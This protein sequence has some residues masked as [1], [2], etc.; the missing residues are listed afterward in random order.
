MGDNKYGYVLIV[1]ILYK[2]LHWDVIF[3]LLSY[4][5]MI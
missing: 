2:R 3:F 4:D 5:E 1:N